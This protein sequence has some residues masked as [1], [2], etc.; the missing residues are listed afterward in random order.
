MYEIRRIRSSEV[1]EAL[2]LAWEV[3]LEFEA[4]DYRPEGTEAF[5]RDIVENEQFITMCCQGIVPIY[6]AFLQE[7]SGEEV[8]DGS[9]GRR[10]GQQAD[11][12]RG[13][14]M[15]IIGMRSETHINLV[16]TRKEYH[17]KGV[18]T[19]IFRYLLADVRR[20]NPSI[21]AITLNASPYG[22][23]FYLHIGFEPQAEEQ[24]RHG[25]RYTPMKYIIRETE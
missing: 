13:R 24:E 2:A 8:W 10:A 3:F 18:A 19:A 11:Q 15:G 6:A 4:P 12:V 22:K 9:D 1:E 21:Q 17:R 5:R 20:K 16:F 14:M 7:E 23:A 25:I